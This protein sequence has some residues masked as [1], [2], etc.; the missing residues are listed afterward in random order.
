MALAAGLTVLTT[1]VAGWLQQGGASVVTG[2]LDGEEAPEPV[3]SV[4]AHDRSHCNTWHLAGAAPPLAKELRARL[5]G[6]EDK[7]FGNDQEKILTDV[8]KAARSDVPTGN[9]VLVT[10]QGTDEKAVVLTGIDIETN[11]ATTRDVGTL[12]AVGAGCGAGMTKRSYRADLDTS[13]PRFE[14]F[15]IDGVEDRESTDFP[16]RISAS[17]PEVLTLV[18]ASQGI[19]RWTARLHWVSGGKKGITEINNAGKPFLSFPESGASVTYMFDTD[20]NQLQKIG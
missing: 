10:I 12:M 7:A 19:A 4:Q 13:N 3:V 18:G 14:T 16:Y 15:D 9:H 11:G 2:F 1:V 5:G 8:R 17:E 20:R 6:G